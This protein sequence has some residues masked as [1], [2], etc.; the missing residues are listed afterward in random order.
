M[1]EEKRLF[2]PYEERVQKL[3]DEKMTQPAQE[4]IA[5]LI[6]SNNQY[7]KEVRDLRAILANQD[8]QHAK[9]LNQSQTS[10]RNTFNCFKADVVV[11]L[12]ALDLIAIASKRQG[13]IALNH[14]VRDMRLE[15]L[16][17]IIQNAIEDF[18]DRVL[19]T[20]TDDF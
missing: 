15:H 3:L 9:A 16:Q 8:Q 14:H 20:Y 13:Q 17:A 1:S 2:I 12:K 6:I 18:G 4:Q 7:Q 10:N 19:T 11:T 5:Q